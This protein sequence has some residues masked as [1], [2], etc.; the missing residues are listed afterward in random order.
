M[1]DVIRKFTSGAQTFF[2]ALHGKKTP[3]E[4]ATDYEIHPRSGLYKLCYWIGKKTGTIILTPNIAVVGN[5]GEEV[6]FGLLK[7][8]REGKK[9]MILWPYELPGRLKFGLTNVEVI[10][11]DSDYRAAPYNSA[12]TIAARLIVTIYF[13]FFRTLSLARRLV[14][15][16]HL[17]N[18]YRIP[19]M[20]ASTLWQPDDVRDFSWGGV[21]QYDWPKQLETP[22]NVFLAKEKQQ[23]AKRERESM[24]LPENAWFVCLHVRQSGFRDSDV[25]KETDA[26]DERN[27]SIINYIGAIEEI[28][29]C[30]GWV[31][32]M[33]DASM[34][35]LPAM[36]R[37]IDYPFT[38]AKSALMDV[39]LISQC[40]L[41]I[42]MMSGIYDV[43]R[44]L[45]CP[46]IMTNMNNWMWTFPIL[47]CDLGVTKHIYSKSRQRFLTLREWLYEPWASVSYSH[48]LG[49]DYVFYENTPDELRAVVREYFGRGNDWKPTQ[50]QCEF[51]E[52]RILRGKELLSER[53]FFPKDVTF[54]YRKNIVDYDLVERYRLASRLESAVGNL[55]TEFLE[56][57]W[58]FD[59][60]NKQLAESWMH[61][62]RAIP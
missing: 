32:R 17:N 31:V 12:A 36:E 2:S 14:L 26:Y 30:G 34:T 47:R 61:Q 58:D 15:G 9:L 51:N 27:A 22:L 48:T 46:M 55:G 43:A 42:G 39:Y 4:L 40:R 45:Q 10:N 24:G 18:V 44:L 33:G 11:V 20:G 6:Y 5:C 25:Y 13:A 28:T 23:L 1:K 3:Q 16:R 49:E 52:T 7:A 59:V 19:I 37:V 53:L 35:R 8:R 29:N 50:L 62:R 38:K 56:Q 60:T 41:Y 21:K 54:N 57:N